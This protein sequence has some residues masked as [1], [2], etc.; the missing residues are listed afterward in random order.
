[1]LPC[2]WSYLHGLL[3][4]ISG[5]LAGGSPGFRIVLFCFTHTWIWRCLWCVFGSAFALPAIPIQAMI[6][7]YHAYSL[8]M[9]HNWSAGDFSSSRFVLCCVFWLVLLVFFLWFG[10]VFRFLLCD[11]IV[12]AFWTMYRST[13]S[14]LL[15][16]LNKQTA[17]FASIIFFRPT[18]LGFRQV[19]PH[20]QLHVA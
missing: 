10:F 18:P 3:Y 5:L 1:M 19:V 4:V 20:V 8:P 11:G 9:L 6:Q 12:T 15:R 16:P 13:T 14:L 7:G 17:I 2:E